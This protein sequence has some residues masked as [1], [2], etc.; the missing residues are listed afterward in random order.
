MSI[1]V[2]NYPYEVTQE[3]LQCFAEYGSVKRVQHPLTVKPGR[4]RGFGFVEMG[5][6]EE[7]ALLKHLMVL[8]GGRASKLIK[9][10]PKKIEVLPL[11]MV[12]EPLAATKLTRVKAGKRF[13][14]AYQHE[15]VCV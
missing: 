9:R 8:N 14:P 4:L 1:Y 12:A 3:D 5:T 15:M 7:T 13:C 2:G 10:S 6:E 11:V